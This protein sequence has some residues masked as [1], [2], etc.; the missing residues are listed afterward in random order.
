M[1]LK[2]SSLRSKLGRKAKRE[3][4][5]R[6]YTLYGHIG[7]R[8]TLEAAWARVRANKGAPGV[9]GVSI[10]EVE[11]SERGVDGFLQEIRDALVARTYKPQP[12]RR[13]YI[14]KANGGTRPLGIPTV[15]DRVVQMAT[16]LIIEP[17]FEQDF[18][19]C[20]YGFRPGRNAHDA[21]TEIRGHG[22][23]RQGRNPAGESPAVPVARFRHVVMPRFM[24]GNRMFI[25]WCKRP[26][27]P[28]DI[29][30]QRWV[31]PGGLASMGA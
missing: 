17:I 2:L 7:R 20:S 19:D 8:D 25:A 6:F 12:V 1:S 22:S 14:P 13:V 4:K 11:S 29:E 24:T 28:V 18:K 23:G 5:F 3:P 9:D 16:V 10:G 30:P 27:R 31:Q 21:L 26:G 15:R